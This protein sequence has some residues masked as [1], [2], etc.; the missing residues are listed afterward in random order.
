MPVEAQARL[1]PSSGGLAL[2]AAA[3]PAVAAPVAVTHHHYDERQ[4]T[5]VSNDQRQLHV[6]VAEPVTSGDD[7]L[8]AVE[9]APGRRAVAA[10]VVP[11]VVVSRRKDERIRR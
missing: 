5:V 7:N 3:R 10:R 11:G 9:G 6:H 1:W 2:P 8:Q 4:V